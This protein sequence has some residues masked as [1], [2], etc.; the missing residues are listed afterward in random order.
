MTSVENAQVPTLEMKEQGALP[1]P[2]P[3]N[4]FVGGSLVS[5]TRRVP[6][7]DLQGEGEV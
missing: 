2:D 3:W 4:R 1:L 6:S 5:V 7:G